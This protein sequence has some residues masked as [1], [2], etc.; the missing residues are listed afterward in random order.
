M[1]KKGLNKIGLGLV[2]LAAVV[3]LVSAGAAQSQAALVDGFENEDALANWQGW[4]G[5][6][7]ALET[8]P[9]YVASG[10]T[11]L[12]IIVPRQAD[13]YQGLTDYPIGVRHTSV[14]VSETPLGISMW[15]FPINAGATGISLIDSDG[16]QATWEYSDLQPGQWN[17]VRLLVREARTISKEGP[18]GN[19]TMD[20][21]AG[22]N[23]AVLKGVLWQG[24]VDQSQP[25]IYYVDDVRIITAGLAVNGRQGGDQAEGLHLEQTYWIDKPIEGELTL[26]AVAGANAIAPPEDRG[27]IA[28]T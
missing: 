4:Y 2:Y 3:C 21:V 24:F 10:K 20:D 12:K 14:Q 27:V 28:P 8:D 11:S 25:A 19:L 6:T 26:P 15:M 1:V 22:V 7:R 16:T 23:I 17:L 18:N 5:G 9:R 13:Y